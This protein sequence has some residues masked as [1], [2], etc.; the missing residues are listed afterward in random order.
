MRRSNM[1]Y[2]DSMSGMEQFNDFSPTDIED[3][4]PK[5][6]MHILVIKGVRKWY[7]KLVGG[8][9]ETVLVSQKYYSKH[10]AR[11]SASKL[12]RA[13]GYGLREVA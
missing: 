10:N 6:P 7:W 12:A 3:E 5:R 8:N 2:E 11:R 4:R 13:N 1:V 9:G